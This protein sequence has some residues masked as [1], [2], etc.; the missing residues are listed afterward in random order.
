MSPFD[1]VAGALQAKTKLT[2]TQ[3]RGTLR[4]ACRE[5]GVPTDAASR[6][7]MQ[8]LLSRGLVP[9]LEARR[10][11]FPSDLLHALGVALAGAHEGGASA[12]YGMF[13]DLD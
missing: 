7:D 2:R 5:L 6:A 9:A 13:D 8:L 11:A 1:A 10:V 4:L 12:L 3:A